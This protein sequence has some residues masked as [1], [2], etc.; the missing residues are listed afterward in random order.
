MQNRSSECDL[1]HITDTAKY[2]SF[3]EQFANITEGIED[4]TVFNIPLEC[5]DAEVRNDGLTNDVSDN[6]HYL[7]QYS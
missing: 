1:L 5:L 7:K 6:Y 3:S 4:D 2:G